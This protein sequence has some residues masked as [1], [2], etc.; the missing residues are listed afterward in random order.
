MVPAV[1]VG[2]IVKSFEKG[3]EISIAD[4]S[5]RIVSTRSSRLPCQPAVAS[6]PWQ[7]R[8]G[9]CTPYLALPACRGLTAAAAARGTLHMVPCPV[10]PPRP[11]WRGSCEGGFVVVCLERFLEM[12][13]RP[14]TVANQ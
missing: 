3:A 11:H 13:V 10:S 4:F 6:L 1:S 8:G 14:V 7:L 12:C 2:E 5:T 9:P